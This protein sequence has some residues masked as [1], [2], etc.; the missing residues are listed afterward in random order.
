MSLGKDSITKRVAKS[1]EPAEATTPTTP[2]KKTTRKT[3]T[4]K[5]PVTTTV[6][7]SIAPEVVEAIV[8]HEENTK[9]DKCALGDDLPYFLL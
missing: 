4:K 2:A 6:V 5:A 1:A 3:T 9:Y 8:G 7:P